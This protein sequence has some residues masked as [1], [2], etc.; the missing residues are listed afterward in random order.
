V[1]DEN[2]ESAASLRDQGKQLETDLSNSP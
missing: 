1:A 2:D